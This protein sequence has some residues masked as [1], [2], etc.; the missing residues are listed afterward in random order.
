[1]KRQEP[2]TITMT[3]ATY[4]DKK[5]AKTLSAK[6][7]DEIIPSDA[8]E[9]KGLSG[10]PEPPKCPYCGKKTPYI[11]TLTKGWIRWITSLQEACSCPQA[12][13]EISKQEAEWAEQERQ[14]QES[15]KQKRIEALIEASG[16]SAR[17]RRQTFER[18]EPKEERMRQIKQLV[19][20]YKDLAIRG[21]LEKNDGLNS[22]FMHGTC[23][24]GKTHLACAVANA[25]I[26]AEKPVLLT[27]FGDLV[28]EIKS[29]FIKGSKISEKDIIEKYRRA[30]MLIIDDLGKEKPTDWSASILFS[31][32][33]H[34]YSDMKPTII[35][36]NFA[37]EETINRIAPAEDD[38][39]CGR[40]IVSRIREVYSILNISTD[41][42]RAQR[43]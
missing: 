17:N 27:T 16:L 24:A 15:R 18:W 23:G 42:H 9:I 14:A 2:P 5:L 12:Q 20:A 32:L 33:N 22:L 25:M 43:H 37:P 11:G 13:A 41:D 40:S 7:P 6:Y 10:I 3:S 38:A 1:M 8:P 21:E 34:R 28:Q 29:T 26:E 19:E 4:V 31:I 36:S 30:P 35:T 39:L